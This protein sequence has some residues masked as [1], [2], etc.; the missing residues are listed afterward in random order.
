[1]DSMDSQ[2]TH[3]GLNGVLRNSVTIKL[4]FVLL[5]VCYNLRN[6]ILVVYQL[7]F[8]VISCYGARSFKMVAP[9]PSGAAILLIKQERNIL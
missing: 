4:F 8:G 6:C 5:S 3:N 1:M 9:N 7:V 2:R